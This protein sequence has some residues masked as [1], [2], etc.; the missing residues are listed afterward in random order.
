MSDN[1]TPYSDVNKV[2]IYFLKNITDILQEN[3]IGMYLYGSLATGYF[4]WYISVIDFIVITKKTVSDDKFKLI[5]E[6][7][8]QFFVSESPWAK[9]I[10]AAYITQDALGRYDINATLYPQIEKGTDLTYA[11]LESGWA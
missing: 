5:D 2:I 8:K 11:K 10:E 9:K 4:D 1:F 7:H 6:M 3:F